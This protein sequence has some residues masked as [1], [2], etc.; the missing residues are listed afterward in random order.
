MRVGGDGQAVAV[1]FG[2]RGAQLAAGVLG[3]L[4]AG[5]GGHVASAGHDLD[6]VG[7][8]VSVFADSVTDA[9]C[10]SGWCAQDVAVAA[11]GGDRRPGRQD[12]RQR[13]VGAGRVAQPE[14]EVTAVAEVAHGR[15]ATAGGAARR[16]GGGGEHGRVVAP[17]E[18]ADRIVRG[19]EHQVH[20]PVHQPGQDRRARHV[21]HLRAVRY[22][23][24]AAGR[25]DNRAV[26]DHGR[27]RQRARA[28]KQVGGAQHSKRRPRP[29]G[30][31]GCGHASS[32]RLIGAAAIG[33]STDRRYGPARRRWRAT[34]LAARGW[35]SRAWRRCDGRGSPRSAR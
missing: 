8:P 6:D 17:R 26:D 2:D 24:A 20:V 11:R 30:R 5:A 13:G 1:R 33:G 3:Q 14:H 19:V 22:G 12:V 16:T 23:E 35:R 27:V 34:R 9:V 29:H 21:D 18:L 10:A 4:R 15:D 7:A 25:E 31:G 32:V 28:V